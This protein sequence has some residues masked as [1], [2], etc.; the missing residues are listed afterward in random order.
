MVDRILGLLLIK[1]THKGLPSVE[2]QR[3]VKDVANIVKDGGDFTVNIVNSRLENLGWERGLIDESTLNLIICLM[4]N[5]GQ[6]K[7]ER[8]TLH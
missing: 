8:Q 3:L 6:I 2:V 4:E 5:E 7:V 1:L